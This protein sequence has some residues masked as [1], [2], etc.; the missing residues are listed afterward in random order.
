M[1]LMSSLSPKARSSKRFWSS[2]F[3]S[4][5]S[6]KS[7]ESLSVSMLSVF[8][9]F[10]PDSMALL[11]YLKDYSY[12]EGC[13][14]ILSSTNL[15]PLLPYG[16]LTGG[17]KWRSGRSVFRTLQI[18]FEFGFSFYRVVPEFKS[19]LLSLKLVTGVFSITRVWFLWVLSW[20]RI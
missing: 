11:F 15:P 16:L 7:A 18:P 17:P 3:C 2:S 6:E 19:G 20:E 8:V 14:E 13:S 10:A 1:G 12:S 9:T 5:N 4:P